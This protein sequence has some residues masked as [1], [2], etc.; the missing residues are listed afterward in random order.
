MF[1]GIYLTTC[2]TTYE[3]PPTKTDKEKL[4]NGTTLDPP[5]T[6]VTPPSGPLQIEKPT[7]DS[8][9]HPCSDLNLISLL[10]SHKF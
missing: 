5:S 8:I 4:T 9:L 6:T 1:N 7:F 3:T 10:K 2:A